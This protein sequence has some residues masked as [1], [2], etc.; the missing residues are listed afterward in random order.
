MLANMIIQR[1]AMVVAVAGQVCS[2]ARPSF[3]TPRFYAHHQANEVVAAAEGRYPARNISVPVD[4]FH[5]DTSYEPHSNDTFELRYWFDASHYVN[6]GPVIVL[7][8]GETSGAE[9]LPFMEKGI[10]YRL[11]RATRG[12]AVVLEHR[13]Y[14]ASFPTPNLTTE[15]LRFLTTDQALADTAYFAKNVVFHGYENRNLTSHT[16]PYFAYGG[17]YA[18]AF[19]AFV[20]KLYP[21]V[22]WG[23]ISSSGVPLAVID[24]WEYC[25]AQRK[26]APSECVDVTQKLTNVLD[27]IA[28]DGEFEDMKKLKEVFGLSNLTNR[29]DFAN[30]LSSG[31]MGWQSLNWN[32]KVSDNLT[33]E[34]CANVSSETIV[35]PE[36]RALKD[37]VQDLLVLGGYEDTNDLETLT[38]Q[39]LNYIGWINATSI[40]GCNDMGAT[41]DECFSLVEPDAWK[42]NDLGTWPWRSWQYQVC[43]QWGYFITG[44][45]Y[46]ENKLPLISRLIDLPYLTLQCKYTFNMTALPDVDHINKLGGLN[47]S[48]PRVAFVDGEADPWL[49]AGVHAPEAPKRNSTDTEPFLLVKGGVHHWDE[50]GLWDNETTVELPPREI[51]NVQALEVQMIQRWLGEWR[52]RSNALDELQLRYTLE[53]TIDV[54]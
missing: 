24:Y 1:L 30:V 46:P 51:L 48:Y 22:F 31:I 11:A 38:P 29:H 16:T 27:T 47:F 8:G 5:N 3:M 23:A 12:M 34:Y 40:K 54:T 28:Q 36:T 44:S 41:Q 37:Q 20:R 4:H 13:Y 33:Y 17:S 43:T 7:L 53:D 50:N 52:R 32:P 26:F 19:A 2:A 21:D 9:R 45:G 49:Y 6:G 14:G 42:K 18:G 15:N 25:E 10:L 39:M 35:Y